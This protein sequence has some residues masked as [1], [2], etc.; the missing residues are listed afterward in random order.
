MLPRRRRRWKVVFP[1][2]LGEY[3]GG[4]GF[5]FTVM[6]GSAGSKGLVGVIGSGD[7]GREGGL[8]RTAFV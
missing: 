7:A 6:V 8:W 5:D 2:S 1:A 4:G 3:F